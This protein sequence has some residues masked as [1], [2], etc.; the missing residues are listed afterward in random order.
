MY[1]CP[2]IP[3]DE[4]YDNNA[5]NLKQNPYHNYNHNG[6][7]EWYH[8]NHFQTDLFQLMNNKNIYS[9]SKIHPQAFKVTGD[10]ST[11][12]AYNNHNMRYS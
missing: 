2:F 3:K 10:T 6:T 7:E 1:K 4:N 5:L 12:H 9:Q 11:V 8:W